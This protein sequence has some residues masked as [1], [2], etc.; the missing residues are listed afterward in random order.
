MQNTLAKMSSIC[1]QLVNANVVSVNIQSINARSSSRNGIARNLHH[2]VISAKNDANG[3]T[4]QHRYNNWHCCKWCM[5]TT[6]AHSEDSKLKSA[7]THIII[8]YF[9]FPIDFTWHRNF[10]VFKQLKICPDLSQIR[11]TCCYSNCGTILVHTQL[12][13]PITLI[14]SAKFKRKTVLRFSR[15]WSRLFQTF[16]VS[17]AT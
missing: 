9:T 3:K 13:I 16:E 8:I 2:A 4:T 1:S 7:P 11:T 14:T 6:Y 10:R 12:S 15:H 5:P 17:V